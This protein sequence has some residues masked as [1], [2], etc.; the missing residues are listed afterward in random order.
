MW[1]FGFLGLLYQATNARKGTYICIIDVQDN[2]PP[3]HTIFV[4][5]RYSILRAILG[6][7]HLA[8]TDKKGI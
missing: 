4:F 6:L 1:F 8:T 3:M 2:Q 7:Q 5:V